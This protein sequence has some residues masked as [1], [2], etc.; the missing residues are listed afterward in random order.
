MDDVMLEQFI[1]RIAASAVYPATPALRSRVIAAI[2][3]PDASP[4]RTTRRPALV[5]AAFAMMA[6]GLVIALA[7]PS[8]RS[9]IA[10]F[11]GV[12]GS[13]IERLPTPA[14]GVTPTP[15]P[16]PSDPASIATP[17]SLDEAE[18]R[19]GFRP[20]APRD[21]GDPRAV[22][23]KT[24]AEV[25]N[26]AILRFEDYDLWEMRPRDVRFGKGLPEGVVE[27]D[28]TVGGRPGYW[29]EGGPHIVY[30]FDDRDVLPGSE[31]TV[32]RD[33]LIWRTDF[34]LYR[35]ETTLSLA[36]A[37]LIAGTLP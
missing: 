20:A 27:R 11:F 35:M 29:I 1:E 22:Y 25:D 21:A 18:R 14:P 34:A 9:A 33:T 31:R 32:T 26:V 23:L 13:K 2:A 6:L 37:I 24:Y 16:P 5:I 30:L 3:R 10:D 36:D 8:S 19:V 7:L 17:V 12:E 4:S 28:T 15:L